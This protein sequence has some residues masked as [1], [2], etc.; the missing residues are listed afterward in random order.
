MNTLV[1]KRTALVF[2]Q[3]PKESA[4]A[5]AA[6]R[7]YLELGPERSLVAVRSVQGEGRSTAGELVEEIDGETSEDGGQQAHRQTHQKPFPFPP[8]PGLVNTGQ[9]EAVNA[10]AKLHAV[11]LAG[12]YAIVARVQGLCGGSSRSGA[13][14]GQKGKKPCQ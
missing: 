11:V 13:M 9:E 4:K 1:N 10:F 12:R 5:F 6:F 7:T 2:E 14:T 8:P 3:Q